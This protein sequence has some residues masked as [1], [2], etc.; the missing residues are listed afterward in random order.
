MLSSWFQK[1]LWALL[2]SF[3][4]KERQKSEKKKKTANH[5]VKKNKKKL[6]KEGRYEV[7]EADE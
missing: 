5:K 1:L 2:N 6:K 3:E 7:A 4:L